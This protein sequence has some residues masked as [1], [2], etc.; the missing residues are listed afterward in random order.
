[1]GLRVCCCLKRL[2]RVHRVEGGGIA[3]REKQCATQYNIIIII[4]VYNATL[5]DFDDDY[6][7]D[8]NRGIYHTSAIK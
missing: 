7:M 5:S 1:V 2:G 3:R 6:F 4:P 8:G